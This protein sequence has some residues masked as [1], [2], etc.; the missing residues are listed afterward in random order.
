[1]DALASMLDKVMNQPGETRQAMA[2]K[3]IRHVRENFSKQAMCD[4]TLDV[5]REFI[6]RK[7]GG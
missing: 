6:D 3:A 2:D 7:A 5:Y 1:M 4:K